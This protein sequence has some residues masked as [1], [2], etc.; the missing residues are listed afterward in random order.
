LL[1]GNGKEILDFSVTRVSP[2]PPE[3]PPGTRHAGLESA[4]DDRWRGETCDGKSAQK[5]KRPGICTRRFY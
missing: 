5:K 1:D 4:F 3:T 2:Q